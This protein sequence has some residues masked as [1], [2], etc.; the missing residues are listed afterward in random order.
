[1]KQVIS[2]EGKEDLLL[3]AAEGH[4]SRGA[5]EAKDSQKEG[6]GLVRGKIK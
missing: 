5:P 1:M 4:K 6:E 3:L 2:E